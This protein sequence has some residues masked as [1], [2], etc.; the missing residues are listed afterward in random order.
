MKNKIIG[1]AASVMWLTSGFLTI[2]L[3]AVSLQTMLE[4]RSAAEDMSQLWNQVTLQDL[5]HTLT[6][7]EKGIDLKLLENMNYY[8][9]INNNTINWT[10]GTPENWQEFLDFCE[11]TGYVV[12]DANWQRYI[13]GELK[14]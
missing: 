6:V 10:P 2:I 12:S 11:R 13:N 4:V 5:R 8:G 7:A 1:T 9:R 3:V 14:P